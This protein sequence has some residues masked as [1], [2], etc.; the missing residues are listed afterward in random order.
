[1]INF[2]NA[3]EFLIDG[4]MAFA[5]DGDNI[6]C[7]LQNLKRSE[8]S[9]VNYSRTHVSRDES[10]GRPME[11]E[12]LVHIVDDDPAVRDSLE[13]LL[14]T[15]GFPVQSHSCAREFLA[16]TSARDAGCVV[17]DMRMP[18][19]SGADLLSIMKKQQFSAPVIIITAH[20]DVSLAV[21]VK[22]LG[23]FDL[24]EKPYSNDA[25]LSAIREA[26]SK[27]DARAARHNELQEVLEKFATLT[28]RENEVL[29]QL[30]KGLPNKSIADELNLGLSDVESHRAAIMAKVGK[31]SLPEL[32]RT[33]LAVR[34]QAD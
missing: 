14:I 28:E 19:L 6:S 5:S 23:A 2:I 10:G 3:R 4:S 21:E 17:T 12:K 25:L 30:L 27:D 29:E 34:A 18:E 13:L 8:S 31:T 26:L 11:N 1:M 33:A 20:A 7:A 16:S 22:K 32:V 9:G 15:E 24:F